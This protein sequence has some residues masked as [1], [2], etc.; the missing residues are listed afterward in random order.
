MRSPGEKTWQ[1]GLR[2]YV[3]SVADA[4]ELP[5]EAYCVQPDPPADAYLAL[6]RR[7]VSFPDRDAALIWDENHGWALAVEAR[8]GEDLIVT[9][10]FG[11][12]IV[13]P[14]EAVVRFVRRAC[15][16]AET[17]AF[18]PPASSGRRCDDVRRRFEAYAD[19]LPASRPS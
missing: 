14:P 9:G 8:C 17:G 10:Y 13:P 15:E 12:D 1:R 7:V 5:A 3:R 18:E 2:E 6:R 11:D 4:L 16:G 19:L